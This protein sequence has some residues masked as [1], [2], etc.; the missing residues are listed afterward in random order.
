MIV[1]YDDI[2]LSLIPADAPA[3][4]GYVN[5]HWPTY[6]EVVRRWPH[7]KHLSIAVSSNA[8]AECLDVEPG[9]ATNSVA[10][11]WVKRQ[12]ARGIKRPVI[13]TSI[14]NAV[15]LLRELAKHGIG[16]E[17]IRL[18]SAHYTNRRHICGPY[19]GF[20]NVTADAT[21]WTSHSHGRSLDESWCKESF[22][23]TAPKP[24]PKPVP[25]PAP[26]PE[27][28]DLKDTA[29]IRIR[30][31]DGEVVWEPLT[32]VGAAKRFAQWQLGKFQELRF[33]RA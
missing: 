31:K 27:P 1:M 33:K 12:Q 14:S 24:K 4:A 2:N 22:F 21:Q 3:V 20:G 32:K 28:V 16:R 15:P 26:D 9:D 19:C 29:Y 13:Y 17:D 5:G 6:R 18:W 10:A 7:A 30:E 23:G 8:D 25:P 11:G